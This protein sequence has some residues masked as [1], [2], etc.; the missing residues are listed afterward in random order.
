MKRDVK[1]RLRKLQTRF[2]AGLPAR[3]DE[4]E[5]AWG[6]A[7]ESAPEDPSRDTLHRLMHNLA[8]AS[9]SFGFVAVGERARLLEVMLKSP[10]PRLTDLEPDMAVGFRDLRQLAARG[11]EPAAGA[12]LAD[13]AAPVEVSPSTVYLLHDDPL[14]AGELV[15]QLDHFGYNTAAFDAPDKLVI[16]LESRRP[17][18]VIVDWSAQSSGQA[19]A[20]M[21]RLLRG[22]LHADLPAVFLSIEE[23]WEARLQAVRAGGRAYLT[24][25]VE[26]SSLVEWLDRLTGRRT[27]T[28]F[29]ILA[30]TVPAETIE[31]VSAD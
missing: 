2:A 23:G 21:V 17:G 14:E 29:R 20:K 16:A 11:I 27:Q 8:G 26:I 13:A 12:V 19:G 9:G 15:R 31:I 30:R 6:A 3:I 18:A 7:R 24:K 10:P 22:G 28:P 1:E 25:P 4:I 5:V